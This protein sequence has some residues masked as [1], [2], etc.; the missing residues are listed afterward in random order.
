MKRVQGSTHAGHRKK[1]D[2]EPVELAAAARL[3]YVTDAVPGITRRRAGKSF[4]YRT[5]DGLPLRHAQTLA[6]VKALAIPPAWTSVWICPLSNGHLQATGRDARGRKQYRYHTRWR[7]LRDETK[8]DKLISFG[9]ALPS[10]RRGTARDLRQQGL[11]REKVLAAAVQLLDR[12]LIRVGN[13]EY[14]RQNE[15]FGLT[16]L[17]N[18]HVKISGP[19]ISFKFNGKSGIKHAIDL[20]DGRLARIVKRCRDLPGQELF[21]YVN[22]DGIL[23]SVESGDL[24]E[25]V[26]MTSRGDFTT[27]DFRTWAASSL[28][29]RALLDIGPATT[30]TEAKRNVVEAVDQVA[31]RLGNT[32]AVCRKCYIHPDVVDAYMDGSLFDAASRL[33]GR[34]LPHLSSDERFLLA[35]LRDTTAQK[36]RAEAPAA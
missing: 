27:K 16:T 10:I 26:L 1:P 36:G 24:N 6:R 23:R 30:T 34:R 19:T 17:R 21:Q 2:S 14:R 13:E 35:F 12:T 5:P 15:S 3:R 31:A 25:Y 9:E 32:R 4:A 22:G 28:A 29:A 33:K 18:E 11:P 8:F 20:S 7:E